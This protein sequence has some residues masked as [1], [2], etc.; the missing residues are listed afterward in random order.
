MECG[1]SSSVEIAVN[2]SKVALSIVK[3]LENICASE[4]LLNEESVDKIN[5]LWPYLKDATGQGKQR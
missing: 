3:S 1:Y 5:K 2:A 4:S